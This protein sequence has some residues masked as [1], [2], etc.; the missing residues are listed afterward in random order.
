VDWK[1]MPQDFRKQTVLNICLLFKRSPDFQFNVDEVLASVF[2]ERQRDGT[3]W[4]GK[5]ARLIP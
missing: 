5:I 1:D 2:N 3:G 4:L